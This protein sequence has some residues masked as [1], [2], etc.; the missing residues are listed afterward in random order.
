M[1]SFKMITRAL[2]TL[3]VFLFFFFTT[4]SFLSLTPANDPLDWR[5]V[6]ASILPVLLVDMYLLKVHLVLG[7]AFFG[8]ISLV[9]GTI[10]SVVLEHNVSVW[11]VL[12]WLVIQTFLA[13]FTP[14]GWYGFWATA[15]F[16]GTWNQ[17][18]LSL[19]WTVPQLALAAWIKWMVAL[20]PADYQPRRHGYCR[21]P[22]WRSCLVSELQKLDWGLSVN[23][24]IGL[25][26]LAR[27]WFA[28]VVAVVRFVT[29]LIPQAKAYESRAVVESDR[30]MIPSSPE[31]CPEPVQPE[32][33]KPMPP[34]PV[35][36]SGVRVPVFPFAKERVKMLLSKPKPCVNRYFE[37]PRLLPAQRPKRPVR[38]VSSL[39]LVNSEPVPTWPN[40]AP[41]F[42]GPMVGP[43]PVLC[44]ESTLGLELFSAPQPVT[45]QQAPEHTFVPASVIVNQPQPAL[46]FPEP[47]KAIDREVEMTDAEGPAVAFSAPEEQQEVPKQGAE[48]VAPEME[49][50]YF[51]SKYLDEEQTA[52]VPQQMDINS[53][54]KT[55]EIQQLRTAGSDVD[56]DENHSG[57]EM[58]PAPNAASQLP[59]QVPHWDSD[60][61]LSSPPPDDEPMPHPRSQPKQ[62]SHIVGG[63][64]FPLP[65]PNQMS[66]ILQLS[67]QPNQPSQPRKLIKPR[68]PRKSGSGK[69]GPSLP[70]QKAI[71][72]ETPKSSQPSLEKGKEVA[73][74]ES[75]SSRPDQTVSS[76]I[77]QSSAPDYDDYEDRLEA[78]I[79]DL[80]NQGINDE[81]ARM[82][83]EIELC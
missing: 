61:E 50:E 77:E 80:M 29:W 15:C 60:S 56:T 8:I 52:T 11:S 18:P 63:L 12:Y 45:Y 49:F 7:T 40:G 79:E 1:T 51:Q 66:P 20:E 43:A 31:T 42:F 21:V 14:L 83:A 67:E 59:R 6:L 70:S 41:M 39:Q 57:V 48:S 24:A 68:S 75:S 53:D 30:R 13:G 26:H 36:P 25:L 47:A 64:T 34:R 23:D 17:G 54:V 10:S 82:M 46:C 55:D 76:P 72:P 73:S 22:G 27:R 28:G 62:A 5:L 16:V 4:Y 58:K 44:P 37:F 65:A 35:Y 69:P 3:S 19:L 38:G 71:K 32:D 74:S 9:I 78:R 33:D 81:T 2:P